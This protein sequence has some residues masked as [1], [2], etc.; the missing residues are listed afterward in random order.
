MIQWSSY[1]TVEL[2]RKR[3]FP[4]EARGSRVAWLA[5]TIGSRTVLRLTSLRGPNM[6]CGGERFYGSGLPAGRAIGTSA[7][8]RRSMSHV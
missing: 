4:I 2:R 1:D 3:G 5:S 7:A 6:G 8:V